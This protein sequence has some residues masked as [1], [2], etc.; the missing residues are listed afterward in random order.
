MMAHYLHENISLHT[1]APSI[2]RTRRLNKGVPDEVSTVLAQASTCCEEAR[3]AAICRRL[4]SACGLFSTAIMLYKR[5]LRNET[6]V[7]DAG[8]RYQIEEQIHHV[9]NE[10]QIYA[11]LHSS[12]RHSGSA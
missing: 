11:A 6:L 2:Q 1:P 5:L 10:Q 8:L 7:R 12:L 3:Q 9:E 4:P